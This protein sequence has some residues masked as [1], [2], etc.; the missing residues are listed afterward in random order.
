MSH[1]N[2]ITKE[3]FENSLEHFLAE[4]ESVILPR[5][6]QDL[7]ELCVLY[8]Y[9]ENFDSDFELGIYDFGTWTGLG[10]T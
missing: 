1:L 2:T 6:H 4:C 3:H 7:Q 8:S 10:G 9:F 5:H